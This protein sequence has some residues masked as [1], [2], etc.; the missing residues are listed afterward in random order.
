MEIASLTDKLGKNKEP[1]KMSNT[2]Q[3]RTCPTCGG[4]GLLCS[5]C[6]RCQGYGYNGPPLPP[7]V[8]MQCHGSGRESSAICMSCL[9]TGY[10]S[11]KP[12]IHS[13]SQPQQHKYPLVPT[14]PGQ[15]Q[16]SMEVERELWHEW[17]LTKARSIESDNQRT[18]KVIALTNQYIS[19]IYPQDIHCFQISTA[20]FIYKYGDISENQ[21]EYNIENIRMQ[22]IC[23]IMDNYADALTPSG[24]D[25]FRIDVQKA[26]ESKLIDY[27]LDAF[28]NERFKLT[29]KECGRGTGPAPDAHFRNPVFIPQDEL[30]YRRINSVEGITNEY[31]DEHQGVCYFEDIRKIV[32]TA[33]I[34]K[35]LTGDRLHAYLKEKIDVLDWNTRRDDDADITAANG[36]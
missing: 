13:L 19:K 25:K 11:T 2:A 3:Q 17:E 31:Y 10:Y 16:F 33:I 6:P 5:P 14:V 27:E 1:Y 32:H 23:V 22:R 8:C 12:K 29:I 21:I 20:D 34:E 35:K 36:Y 26:I 28:L 4:S 7:F 18:L 9:G 30:E 24:R 15:S